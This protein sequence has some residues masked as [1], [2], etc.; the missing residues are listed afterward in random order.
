VQSQACGGTML[1]GCCC[2]VTGNRCPGRCRTGERTAGLV[3][4]GAG[5]ASG[6]GPGA[7]LTVTV[8]GQRLAAW[9]RNERRAVVAE[10]L[11]TLS[12]A[13]RL[14]LVAGLTELM[15]SRAVPPHAGTPPERP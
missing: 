9:I 2:T 14:A 15:V 3:A 5:P 4:C 1:R 6:S 12:S 11:E 13:G 10:E 7:N 8:A